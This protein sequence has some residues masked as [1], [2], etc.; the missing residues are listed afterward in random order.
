[1]TDGVLANLVFHVKSDAPTGGNFEINILE[2]LPSTRT[3]ASGPDG[4]LTLIPAPTDGFDANVDKT[5]EVVSEGHVDLEVSTMANTT[6]VRRGGLVT[7]VTTVRNTG[8]ATATNV[9]V[10]DVFAGLSIVSRRGSVGTL[11]VQGNLWSVGTLAPGE[12]A[13]VVVVAIATGSGQV[14]NSAQV[15]SVSEA[16]DPDSTA[17]NGTVG[18]ASEDDESVFTMDVMQGRRLWGSSFGQRFDF[19]MSSAILQTLVGAVP[20]EED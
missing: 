13:S 11:L 17:G 5:F 15:V 9:V 1:G 6:A 12:S 10:E 14:T 4:V 16:T 19:G 2:S 8:T 3:K 20:G 7:F 18:V